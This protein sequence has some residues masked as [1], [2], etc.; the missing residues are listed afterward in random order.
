MYSKYSSLVLGIVSLAGICSTAL[1]TEGQGYYGGVAYDYPA[2]HVVYY[3]S[4]PNYAHSAFYG[5]P[6]YYSYYSPSC[7][8]YVRPVYCETSYGDNRSGGSDDS[9]RQP[10]PAKPTTV[11]T[12][13]AYDNRFSPQTIN[14]QLGTTV[15]WVNYGQHAHTVTANNDSWD[16]GDIKPGAAY[17]ATFKQPGTYYYYCRHHTQDK[18]QGVI[19]VGSASDSGNRGTASSGY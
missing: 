6:V 13:G 12:V 18:M 3:G 9:S 2:Q 4:A 16:S 17:S 5:R 1:K 14:V 15:R 8:Y 10:T 19:V 7:V 11:T